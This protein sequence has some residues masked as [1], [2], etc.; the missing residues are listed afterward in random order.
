[1][2]LSSSFGLA[3]GSSRNKFDDVQSL[4]EQ[5]CPALPQE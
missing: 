3:A 2:P 5:P 1:M 4:E